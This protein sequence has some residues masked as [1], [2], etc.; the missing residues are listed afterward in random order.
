MKIKKTIISVM[1]KLG[2]WKMR[3]FLQNEC[4]RHHLKKNVSQI[5]GNGPICVAFIV[6]EPAM[7]DKQ[8]P[9]YIE[10]LEKK[11]VEPYLIVVPDISSS[12]KEM[13]NKQQFF[14]QNYKNVILYDVNTYKRFEQG[15]FQY[16][17]FQTPYCFKYP[18]SMQPYKIVKH[19]KICYIPYGYVGADDFFEVT[20]QVDFF[21]NVYFGFMDNEPM[22]N[23]LREKFSKGS[24]AG[25]QHFEFV[26]YP[27]F[28]YYFN[29]EK[30]SD[31]I[32][33]VLWIPRWSY[34]EVGGG[35]HFLEYKDY[36]NLLATSYP[37]MKWMMRPHPLMFS[38]LARQ[39]LFSK[40]AASAYKRALKDANIFLDENSLLNDTLGKTDL[41]IADYSSIIIMFFLSG[42]PIIYCDG[43]LELNGVY[44]ELKDAIYI[45]HS[46]DE[47]MK[48]V[49]DLKNGKDPLREHRAKIIE[50]E[51][52][53]HRGATKRVVDAIVN[54]YLL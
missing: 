50:K 37:D 33:N 41:L 15:E 2:I 38:T 11:G 36:Y 45:A 35:S 20:T 39:G 23:L 9:V 12:G 31:K 10:M 51:E 19:T 24:T 7:W 3:L 52:K 17:F 47:V 25:I 34:A 13:K 4:S 29:M 16:T 40:D 6:Y 21:A 30:P 18:K 27:S 46:W 54:D 49:H 8:E 5:R 44:S 48:Y 14:L 22:K 53:K 42:R 26:G 28:E 43:G 32:Q 1:E